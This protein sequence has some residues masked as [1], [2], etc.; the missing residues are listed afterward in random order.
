VDTTFTFSASTLTQALFCWTESSLHLISTIWSDIESPPNPPLSRQMARWQAHMCLCG[1]AV[2]CLS[3]LAL[4]MLRSCGC[5]PTP[6]AH[7]TCCW[8]TTLDNLIHLWPSGL[9]PT[10]IWIQFL[11]KVFQFDLWFFECYNFFRSWKKYLKTLEFWSL[12]S[13]TF[14]WLPV[15]WW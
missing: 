7:R 4:L 8:I 11:Q 2:C 10:N 5:S 13:S 3:S 9:A 12:L 14:F 1:V 6:I 15:L